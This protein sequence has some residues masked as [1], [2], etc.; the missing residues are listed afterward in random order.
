MFLRRIK[1]SY[2]VFYSSWVRIK[3]WRIRKMGNK[4]WGREKIISNP[5][6][7]TAKRRGSCGDPHQA[8]GYS[9]PF[10]FPSDF[11]IPPIEMHMCLR[12]CVL[13]WFDRC[14]SSFSKES[15]FVLLALTHMTWKMG[16]LH[17]FQ[18][19]L[20]ILG[21]PWLPH[22]PLWF[23]TLPSTYIPPLSSCQG[24]RT[25]LCLIYMS[26]ALHHQ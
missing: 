24:H 7:L 12:L 15:C 9:G 13:A 18:T 23:K 8:G 5:H 14:S 6:L 10:A 20:V 3:W 19:S 22:F 17:L 4:W 1:T 2:K 26:H 21:P 11:P 25:G 16:F